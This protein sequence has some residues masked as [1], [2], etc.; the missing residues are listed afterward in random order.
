MPRFKSE[1][2]RQAFIKKQKARI[3]DEATRTRMMALLKGRVISE[4][5]RTKIS[6]TL[7]GRAVRPAGWNHSE[8]SKKLMSQKKK[9][10]KLSPEAIEKMAASKRGKKNPAQS[11]RM[12]G[13]QLAKALKGRKQDP[14]F[15]K[16]RLEGTA[17]FFEKWNRPYT[18]LEIQLYKMLL[19]SG[20][21]FIPQ[22]T[23][24]TRIVDAYIPELNMAFEADGSYWHQDKQ[25]MITR[26]NYLFARGITAIIHMDEKDLQAVSKMEV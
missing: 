20:Y 3:W 5:T 15:V 21:S 13:N 23:F 7:K 24:G 10:Q 25:D 17:K 16:R 22:K 2:T 6:N 8:E 18:R 11:E 1:E 12:K 26:D 4:E 14:E 19:H 9:G